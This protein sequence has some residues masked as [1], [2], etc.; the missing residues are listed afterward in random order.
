M[1]ASEWSDL[2]ADAIL[3]VLILLIQVAFF[4]FYVLYYVRLPKILLAILLF[5]TS[6]PRT[7]AQ[8]QPDP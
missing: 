4:G 3:H 6:A 5:A 2:L 8:D 7:R 1:C